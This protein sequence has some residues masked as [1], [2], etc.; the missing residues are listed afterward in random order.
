[1]AKQDEN[2]VAN[3]LR[4]MGTDLDA[5]Y[6]LLFGLAKIKGISFMFANATCKALGF[7]RDTKIG[8][9]SE[10]EV[11]K[12]E[13]FLANPKKEGIPEWLLNSRKD[14][15]T[16]ENLH[17]VGKDIEYNALQLRRRLAK[18]KSYRA[19]RTKHK[20]TMRGQRT[21]SNFRRLKTIRSMKSKA[22]EGGKR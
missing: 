1:M 13:D 22:A 7:N 6:T 20:L 4:I 5:D 17:Y 19:I 3:L 15:Q 8:D 10:K 18:T 14:V 11:E 12:L 16:G 2:K 9:L 21:K